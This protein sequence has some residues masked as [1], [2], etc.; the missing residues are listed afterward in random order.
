MNGGR[1][2]CEGFRDIDS[3]ALNAPDGDAIVQVY[4]NPSVDVDPSHLVTKAFDDKT[5][6]AA[7]FVVIIWGPR[8][9]AVGTITLRATIEVLPWPVNPRKL[10]RV[11]E[12]LYTKLFAISC[13][14]TGVGGLK[15]YW[16]FKNSS[17]VLVLGAKL[18]TVKETFRHGLPPLPWEPERSSTIGSQE[19]MVL[20]VAVMTDGDVG[21]V[22]AE[23]VTVSDGVNFQWEQS[24]GAETTHSAFSL[25]DNI[26]K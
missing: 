5:S 2:Y 15:S 24:R 12:I 18:R 13:C 17:I 23:T 1:K 16:E 8:I 19:P 7:L 3:K 20:G 10:V 4:C 22:G 11:T 26:V 9:D 25:F 21:F 14:G 6:D